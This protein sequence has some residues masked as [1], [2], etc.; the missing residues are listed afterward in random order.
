MCSS[1]GPYDELTDSL[2]KDCVYYYHYYYYY[3]LLLLL[4]FC[5]LVKKHYVRLG[6]VKSN[7]QCVRDCLLQIDGKLNKVNTSS[8]TMQ[9]THID[10]D[11]ILIVAMTMTMTTSKYRLLDSLVVECWLRVREVPGSIPSQGPPPR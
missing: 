1:I 4:L 8:N 7:I 3:Y 9:H 5:S 2:L 6:K 10:K 11:L